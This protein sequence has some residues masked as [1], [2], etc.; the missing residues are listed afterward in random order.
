M[1]RHSGKLGAGRLMVG[2]VFYLA[3]VVGAVVTIV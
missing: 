2:G 3:F 1:L